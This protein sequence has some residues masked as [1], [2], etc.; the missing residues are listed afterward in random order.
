MEVPHGL[1]RLYA[2]Q[3]NDGFWDHG[4][5]SRDL[6]SHIAPV[7]LAPDFRVVLERNTSLALLIHTE[8]ARSELIVA[9][10]LADLWF[11]TDRR[12]SLYS[13]QPLDVDIPAGLN[14]ICDFL[15]GRSPQL[16]DVT[17]PFVVVVEAK[18]DDIPGAYGQCAAELVA[19]MRAN[20]TAKVE[21]VTIFGCATT[22]SVW[23][24]MKLTGTHLEIDA[25]EYYVTQADRI[26]GIL[27]HMVGHNLPQAVT[28]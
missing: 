7:P 3:G 27:L 25:A 8:K 11:R 22:G 5:T 15:I 4:E 10:I 21:M 23:R 17:P 28:A 12:I 2:R 9:P 14:G 20:A 6:F 1:Q 19:A 24:F 13:G 16:P 18:K 26:V